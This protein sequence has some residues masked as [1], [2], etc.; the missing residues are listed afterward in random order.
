MMWLGSASGGLCRFNRKTGK[1]LPE[2]FDLGYPQSIDGQAEP[3]DIINC[4]YKDQS[5]TLWV[6][7]NSG[8][9]K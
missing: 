2:N 5:G 9:H 1:F 6:G 4:I 8:L 7:N 3:R